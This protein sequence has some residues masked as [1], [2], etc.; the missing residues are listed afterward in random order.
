MLRWSA[1]EARL[2]LRS[3]ANDCSESR[4][5]LL[6][7]ASKPQLA[8]WPQQ[9]MRQPKKMLEARVLQDAST[10][11]ARLAAA[12]HLHVRELSGVQQLPC[13]RIRWPR[14]NKRS[15]AERWGHREHSSFSVLLAAEAP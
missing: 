7:V 5:L 12:T 3:A 1:A 4:A 14:R 13:S 6:D 15:P 2:M 11:K 9:L 8:K 10:K